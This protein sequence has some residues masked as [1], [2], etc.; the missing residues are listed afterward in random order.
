[1]ECAVCKRAVADFKLVVGSGKGSP[2]GQLDSSLEKAN[3]K[4]T[5]TT[6]MQNMKDQTDLKGKSFIDP[7]FSSP[8]SATTHDTA[9]S[10]GESELD[11]AFEFGL[12]FGELRAS[13]PKFE[14]Q[15][16][17][18]APDLSNQSI[19]GGRGEKRGDSNAVLRI[20]NVPWVKH[21]V[22]LPYSSDNCYAGHNTSSN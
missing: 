17:H 12:D 9:S 11:S 20:D 16:Q 8:G 19:N 13:T 3:K 2:G 1:M 14:Q 22:M 18:L 7:L 10:S 21:F 4:T 5:T 15:Q 6:K